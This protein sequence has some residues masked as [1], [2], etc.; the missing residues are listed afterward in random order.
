MN[1]LQTFERLD[2]CRRVTGNYRSRCE[3][4][5]WL[6]GLEVYERGLG[7]DCAADNAQG[8]FFSFAS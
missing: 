8:G 4:G 1:W 3:L 5:N 6:E 7:D 2:R